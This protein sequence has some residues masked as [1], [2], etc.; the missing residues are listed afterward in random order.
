[1][2]DTSNNKTMYD[3]HS[4]KNIKNESIGVYNIYMFPIYSITIDFS[5]P[6]DAQY[7]LTEL[8]NEIE[9]ECPVGKYFGVSDVGEGLVWT[10]HNPNYH[11]SKYWF[12]TKSDKH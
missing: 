11:S 5:N 12:K 8:T 9:Q 3:A 6:Q 7:K 4:I 2:Y 1:M 10:C